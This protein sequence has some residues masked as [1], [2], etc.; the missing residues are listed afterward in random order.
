MAKEMSGSAMNTTTDL[1]YKKAY[2]SQNSNHTLH[3]LRKGKGI[4]L[5]TEKSQNHVNMLLTKRPHVKVEVGVQSFIPDHH[6]L[7][8]NA[9]SSDQS[10]LLLN[11]GASCE[12]TP[13]P[14]TV[15]HRASVHPLV[16]AA[17]RRRPG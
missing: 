15:P 3:V 7:T 14:A 10:M 12:A 6:A 16:P 5:P 11:Q 4:R 13:D 1:R 2:N 8:S 17:P 9:K